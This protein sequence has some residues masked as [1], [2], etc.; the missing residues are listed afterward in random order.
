VQRTI[1]VTL[2]RLG[3]HRKCAYPILILETEHLNK[4][5]LY[6]A[7]A[8]LTDLPKAKTAEVVDA[9]FAT[10]EATLKKRKSYGSLALGAL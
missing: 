5:E 8:D 7:V 9:V 3:R 4:S 10:I 6:A 1:A 2:W